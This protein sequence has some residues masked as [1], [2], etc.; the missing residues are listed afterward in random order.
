M[1]PGFELWLP[2]KA[3]TYEDGLPVWEIL[4]SDAQYVQF[5]LKAGRKVTCFSG[6]MAYMSDN[7]KM[8]VALAGL[9]KTFG[10]LAGGGSLF[11]I[12]YTNTSDDEN[13]Y[14]AMT[15]DYPGII[16]PISMSESGEI[17]AQRDSFLCSTI[18]ESGV[19]TEV[20]AGFNPSGSI[21]SFCCSGFDF[22]MQKVENGE[23]AFLIAMGTVITKVLDAG[24]SILVDTESVLAI[25]SSVKVEVKKVG[26]IAAMCCAGQGLFNTRFEGPGKVWLQSMSIDKLRKLFPPKVVQSGGGGDGGD[27][28]DD[29]GDWGDG[30]GD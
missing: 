27:G 23:W 6:A 3:N 16:V 26:G 8:D 18:D 14:I 11:K 30:G 15:P 25:Q 20:G 2:P 5:P 21:V 9:M 24:E 1:L 29:G 22:I 7:M 4:G 28:G 10:R 12:T 13:G 19:E 17:L